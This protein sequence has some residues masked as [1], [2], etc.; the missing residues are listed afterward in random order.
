MQSSIV[1]VCMPDLLSVQI[2]HF[3]YTR[4]C[5]DN[6]FLFEAVINRDHCAPISTGLGEF[7]RLIIRRMIYNCNKNIEEMCSTNG[8]L[9]ANKGKGIIQ[10]EEKWLY[11]LEEEKGVG[12]R[13][14]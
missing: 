3:L 12:N 14:I 1:I 7:I 8:D 13:R 11:E 5:A 9:H 6:M 2:N 4:H 10:A